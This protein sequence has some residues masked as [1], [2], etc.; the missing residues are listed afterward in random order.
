VAIDP[1]AAGRSAVEHALPHVRVIAD[2]F[3][4]DRL[5]GKMVTDVRQPFAGATRAPRR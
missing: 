1:C 3:H 2:H 4:L 5:A